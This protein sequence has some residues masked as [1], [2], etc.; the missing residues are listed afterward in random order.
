MITLA[1]GQMLFFL[2][3]SLAPYGGDDGMTIPRAA[4]RGLALLKNDLAL[5]LGRVRSACSE[6]MCS[7]APDRRSRFGRVLRGTRE[8]AIRMEAIGFHVFRYQLAAYVIS[9]HDGGLAGFPARQPDGVRQPCLHDLAAFRRTDL[10]GRARRARH[11]AWRD[12]RRGR[13]PAAG[14]IPSGILH[15]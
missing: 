15:A 13:L 9:R 10:H 2:A 11:P 6:P 14:G 4:R 7:A 12:P 5:L 8:N 1:F 3:T